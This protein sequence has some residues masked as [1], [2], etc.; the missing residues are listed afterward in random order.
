MSVRLHLTAVAGILVGLHVLSATVAAQPTPAKPITAESLEPILA[1]LGVTL[2]VRERPRWPQRRDASVA[3]TLIPQVKDPAPEVVSFGLPFGPDVLADDQRIRVVGADGREIA[4]FTRPLGFWGIDGKKSTIRSVLIQFAAD[5]KDGPKRVTVTWDRVRT[6]HRQEPAPIADTQFIRQTDGFDFH[7]PKVLAVLPADWLCASLVAW[8]QIPASQNQAAP[9][10]DQHLTEQFP[11]SLRWIASKSYEA[12]LYDRPATYAKIYVRHGEADY[13]LAALKANDFY[14]QHLGADGFFDLKPGDYKYVYAEGSTITYL[15]TGDDRYRQAVERSLQSWAKWPRVQYT[16]TGFWTERHAGT[17]MAA[18][19]HAYE[20]LGD[21]KLLDVA[22]RYFDGVLDLQF[23]P[24]DG[25]PPD[26][27]W[28]HTGASHGDG[29]GWTTSPWMSALLMDSIWKLWMI[30]GDSRC[31]ASLAAYAKFTEKHSVTADGRGVWYMANSPGRGKSVKPES[32]PHNMEAAYVLAMGYYLSGGKDEGLLQKI[33]TLWPPLMKDA[34]NSP[35]RKFSWRFR[36]TS[37]LVWFLAHARSP[38]GA[39]LREVNPPAPPDPARVV[40]VVGVQL[41]D[42]RGGPPVADA[43][44]V[45]RGD[46]IVAAGRRDSVSVPDGAEIVNAPGASLVPGLIDAHFHVERLYQLPGLFLK[47]GVTSLRDPGEWIHVYDPIRKPDLPMPRFFLT[48]PHLDQ[49]PVAHPGT[50]YVVESAEETRRAV[51]RFVDEGA[52]AIKV[53]YRLPADLIQVACATA[54]ERGLPVTAHL[55]IVDADAAIRAGLDGVEHVTSFGTA[56]ADPQA[57]ERFRADVTLDNR[58]RGPGRYALW[59]TID[60]DR[61]P[62][63]QPLIDLLLARKTVVS[64]TLAVFE[65][66]RGDKGATD[67][68]VR[69]YET[70]LRF[71]G[72]CHRAGVPIVVGSHSEVPKAERG[73]AYHRELELLAECGLTPMEVIGAATRNNAAFF[74]VSDRLGTIEPDKQADLVLIDGDPLKDIKS[75]RRVRGVML[76]GRWVVAPNAPVP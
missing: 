14:I 2:R 8:Q 20:L 11:G 4:A 29:N 73:W 10:Y 25:K 42:G 22:R 49:K 64:P 16:G 59:S 45:V 57:A 30:T 55:E 3:V 53:Y 24:L 18:Y 54:H 17:G 38:A 33:G 50:S 12:H 7:C 74:R 69:G 41:I 76:G 51:R 27:A 1:N 62:R 23:A 21:P 31:P 72:M 35:G 60:L 39:S 40:A 36:E 19:L 48:G 67:D 5:F 15:L 13:L 44:V 66:R 9:W 52:S 26:G 61:S 28:L 47:H 6:L 63:V 43:A 37:M 68:R 70:M 75:M 58:A 34:A 32:P 56:L 46:R 65:V 71:V